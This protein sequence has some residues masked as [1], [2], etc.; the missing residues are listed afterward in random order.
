MITRYHAGRYY[1]TSRAPRCL[2]IYV[3][4]PDCRHATATFYMRSSC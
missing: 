2:V 1:L 4:T 3:M